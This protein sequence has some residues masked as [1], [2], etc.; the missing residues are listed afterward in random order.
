MSLDIKLDYI[1]RNQKINK[2]RLILSCGLKELIEKIEE[3]D[4]Y[5]LKF[6]E[7]TGYNSWETKSKQTILNWKMSKGMTLGL[8]QEIHKERINQILNWKQRKGLMK[9]HYEKENGEWISLD[10]RIQWQGTKGTER[11][12]KH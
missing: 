5:K 6:E 9:W 12:L 10:D 4:Y 3:I 11:W 7:N 2:K 8:K 1:T